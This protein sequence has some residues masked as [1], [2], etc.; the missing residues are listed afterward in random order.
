MRIQRI[1][2]LEYAIDS[3]SRANSK[4]KWKNYQ[5]NTITLHEPI[6]PSINING[7]NAD[8]IPALL[9]EL[10][11]DFQIDEVLMSEPLELF[12]DDNSEITDY[13]NKSGEQ[14][15]EFLSTIGIHS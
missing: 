2:E 11:K 7:Y 14:S 12:K 3:V 4:I 15:L 13:I 9:D 1:A 10:R 8:L 5:E 6:S